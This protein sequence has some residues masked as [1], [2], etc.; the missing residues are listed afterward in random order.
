MVEKLLEEIPKITMAKASI[1]CGAHARALLH[2][3]LH[4]R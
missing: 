4:I 3:E 1:C 2:A